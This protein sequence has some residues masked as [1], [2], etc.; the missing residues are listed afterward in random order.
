MP[1]WQD[2]LAGARLQQA[3]LYAVGADR[4]EGYQQRGSF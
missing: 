2:Q 4:I 3:A 1:T